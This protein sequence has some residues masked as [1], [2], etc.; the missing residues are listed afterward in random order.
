MTSEGNG[1]GHVEDF[2]E[3]LRLRDYSPNTVRSYE[4]NL[5]TVHD[6]LAERQATW[7]EVG[8]DELRGFL[9]RLQDQDLEPDTILNYYSSLSTF[10]EYLQMEEIVQQNPVEPFRA[11][12][13]RRIARQREQKRAQDRH[14]IPSVPELRELIQSARGAR[15]RAIHVLLA[16]TGMRR[17]ELEAL[18]ADDIDFTELSVTVPPH[19]KRAN[20]WGPFDAECR[21]ALRDWFALRDGRAA[22]GETACFVGATGTRLKRSGI[23]NVVTDEAEHVGLHDPDSDDPAETFGPHHYRHWF[24]SVLLNNGCPREYV[25]ELRGDRR[26]DAVDLYHHIDKTELRRAYLAAMPRLGIYD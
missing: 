23:Y 2:V 26:Q 17:G 24:T 1:N 21:R 4:S 9:Q 19:P 8:T 11:R 16:K 15:N 25:K 7:A 5:D 13:L 10:Y 6:F 20:T 14:Q 12:Y 18:G 22:E 3:D